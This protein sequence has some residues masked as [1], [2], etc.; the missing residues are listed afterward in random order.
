[1]TENLG[2]WAVIL[3][4]EAVVDGGFPNPVEGRPVQGGL[5]YLVVNAPFL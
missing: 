3:R 5:D 1:M 2:S 4:A